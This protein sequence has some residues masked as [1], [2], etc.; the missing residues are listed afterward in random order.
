MESGEAVQLR[1]SRG[2]G[3]GRADEPARSVEVVVAGVVRLLQDSQRVRRSSHGGLV[4]T[5]VVE[6]RRARIRRHTTGG[7]SGGRRCRSRR[8]RGALLGIVGIRLRHCGFGADRFGAGNPPTVERN[9][10]ATANFGD[11]GTISRR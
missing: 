6:G 2:S 4:R 8:R 7:R 9:K 11:S 5:P 1:L 10:L 3:E